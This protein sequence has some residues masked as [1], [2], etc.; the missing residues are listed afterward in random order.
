MGQLEQL[1]KQEN[2]I[3]ISHRTY[4]FVGDIRRS[5]M[6]TVTLDI[7]QAG[8]IAFTIFN[9]DLIGAI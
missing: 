2:S 6:S 5:A 1:E 8:T 7:E 4:K 3:Q 9:I